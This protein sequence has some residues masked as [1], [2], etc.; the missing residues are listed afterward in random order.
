MLNEFKTKLINLPIDL[1][2][3][4]STVIMSVLQIFV[5]E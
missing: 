3:N 2:V 5:D 1:Q 4:T